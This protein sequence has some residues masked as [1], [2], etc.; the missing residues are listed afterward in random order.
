M[1]DYNRSTDKVFSCTF[2][3]NCHLSATTVYVD[4]EYFKRGSDSFKITTIEIPSSQKVSF[5]NYGNRLP[6]KI[7]E[8][9]TESVSIR[10]NDDI[11]G[12]KVTVGRDNLVQSVTL[13]YEDGFKASDE[14]TFTF[15][16]QYWSN[17]IWGFGAAWQAAD[18]YTATCSVEELLSGSVTLHFER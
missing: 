3:T 11:L 18:T 1:D 5:E 12:T 7:Y 15:E 17:G 16:D 14:L 2:L 9:G 6:R 8:G 4:N 10:L 13:Q